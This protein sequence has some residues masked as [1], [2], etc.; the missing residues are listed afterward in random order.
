MFYPQRAVFNAGRL[1]VRPRVGTSL[2]AGP[3]RPSATTTREQ[4]QS[5]EA[6]AGV[7][8]IDRMAGTGGPVGWTSWQR[9]I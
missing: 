7:E 2:A 5:E 8:F 4:S 9:P 6:A 1:P 3:R